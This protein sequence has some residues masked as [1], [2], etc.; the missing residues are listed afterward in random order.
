MKEKIDPEIIKARKIAVTSCE[1]LQEIEGPLALVIKNNPKE[2]MGFVNKYMFRSGDPVPDPVDEVEKLAKQSVDVYH[3]LSR[4]VAT[5][6]I[7]ERSVVF[8]M[9]RPR[10]EVRTCAKL[11]HSLGKAYAYLG[12]CWEDSQLPLEVAS[13]MADHFKR[14]LHCAALVVRTAYEELVK[15]GLEENP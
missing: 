1:F 12:V 4:L 10:L 13:H 3:A 5:V 8:F 9:T 11:G 6:E 7:K 14:C 15:V 2:F